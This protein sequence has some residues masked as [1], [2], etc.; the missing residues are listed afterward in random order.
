M[1]QSILLKKKMLGL[2]HLPPEGNRMGSLMLKRFV[3]KLK[4]R[5][6]ES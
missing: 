5:P 6:E 1:V 3:G 2:E 4:Q